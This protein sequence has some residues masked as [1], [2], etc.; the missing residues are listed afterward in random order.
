[1]TGAARGAG[2][3][4]TAASEC[5]AMLGVAAGM[6]HRYGPR[7][8]GR[9]VGS[10]VALSPAP[11]GPRAAGA[12]LGLGAAS[13]PSPRC[14]TRAGG[15]RTPRPAP[16]GRASFPR[17]CG[18]GGSCGFPE[19]SAWSERCEGS[20]RLGAGPSSDTQEVLAELIIH[21]LALGIWYRP[22]GLKRFGFRTPRKNAGPL[23]AFGCVHKHLLY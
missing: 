10:R 13:R 8:S 22:A 17:S 23:R 12:F 6:T 11:R 3:Q 14:L 2:V 21:V 4:R 1:M 9:H 20:R 5:G 15:L 18:Q 19:V 16:R 7:P